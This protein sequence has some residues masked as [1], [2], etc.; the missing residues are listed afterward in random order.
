MDYLAIAVHELSNI[1]ERR[2]ERLVN[3]SLS[4]LPAFLINNPGKNCGFM[5]A[6]VTAV[7]LVSE[8]KV[9]CH[10]SSIDTIPTSA[11]KE[12]HVSMGGFAARKALKVIENVETVLAIELLLAC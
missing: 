5:M 3:P 2:I 4:K 1:S 7:S 11:N 12:D 9:F 8:N 6:H 10:P